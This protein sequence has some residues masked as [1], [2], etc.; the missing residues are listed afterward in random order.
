MHNYFIPVVVIAVYLLRR[1]PLLGAAVLCI[2]LVAGVWMLSQGTL[3]SSWKSPLPVSINFGLCS[4]NLGT[5]GQTNCQTNR[6]AQTESQLLCSYLEFVS[7]F[8][9]VG[10]RQRSVNAS[11]CPQTDPDRT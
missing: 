8:P 4:S 2:A 9:F 7:T 11:S 1:R 10:V 5:I 3:V 6:P